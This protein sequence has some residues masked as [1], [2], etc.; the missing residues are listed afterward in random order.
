MYLESSVLGKYEGCAQVTHHS[1]KTEMAAE[2]E[3]GQV[4]AD[5]LGILS[6]LQ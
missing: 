2:P 3:L 1:Q 5:R 6:A 4:G